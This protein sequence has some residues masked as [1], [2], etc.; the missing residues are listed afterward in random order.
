MGNP[1]HSFAWRTGLRAVIAVLCL[2]FPGVVMGQI[3][4]GNPI[5]PAPPP[6]PACPCAPESPGGPMTSA[7]GEAGAGCKVCSSS[8]A[9]AQSGVYFTSA[10]DLQLATAGPALVAGRVYNTSYVSSGLTGSGWTSN[11]AI[12]LTYSVYLY[13]APSTYQK[14]V[15]IRM[16]D[17]RLF[18]FMENADGVTYTPPLGRHDTLVKQPDGSWTLNVQNSRSAWQFNQDGSLVSITDDYGN[19]QTWSYDANGHLQRITDVGSGRYLDVYFGADGRLSSVQDSTGR[20]VQYTYN[21]NGSLAT[22]TDPLNHVTTY[23][24]GTGRFGPI[25]TQ[26]KDQWNRVVA[27][28]TYDSGDRVTSYNE[29][30]ETYTYDYSH[31]AQGYTVKKDSQNNQWTLAYPSVGYIT[32]VIAPGGAVKHTD[33]NADGSIQSVT[34]EVGIRTNYTY[35]SQGHV[36]TVARDVTHNGPRTDY[37]YDTNFP[38]KV[39]TVTVKNPSTNQ[40]DPNWQSWRYDYY[41][42]TDAAPGALHHVYRVEND[43]TT[44]DTV[45]TYTYDSHGRITQQI[46]ATGATTD[47]TYDTQGNLATVT[48]PANN[49]LGTRPATTYG[50]DAL[51]RVTSVTDPLGHETTATYDP[52]GRV[53]TVALPPPTQNSP[54]VF[55]TTYTYDNW[56]AASGLVFTTVTDP[57]GH[58]NRQGYDQLGRLVKSIDALGNSTT[59]VYTRDLLTSITDANNNVT[60]YAYDALKRLATTT[61]PDNASESYTYWNDGLLHTRTDRKGQTITYAYDAIKRLASKTYPGPS[62]ITYTY[63]GQRLTQVADTTV[64]PSETHTFG[65]DPSYRINAVTEGSR[66]TLG[67]TYASNDR[68]ATMSVQGGPTTTYAYY[69]DG[70]LDTI[71]WSPVTGQFKYAYMLNG[72]Y[73]AITFPNG[74]TRSYGYDDQGRLTALANVHPTAGTLASFAYGYDVDPQTQQATLLGQRTSLAMTIPSQSLTNATSTYR[75][76]ADY[77]LIQADYPTPAPYNGEVHGWTYDAIGNRLTNTV[78]GTPQ[79]YAYFKNGS[80]PL[81]GQRLSSDSDNAYTYDANGNNLTRNGTPGNFTFGWSADDRMASISGSATASYVYDYQGRRTSKTVSGTTRS[82]L[83][84]GSDLIRAT[85]PST[86]AEY[87]FGPDIDEPLATM[88]GGNVAYFSVDGLGSA[89]VVSDATGTVDNAYL[90]DAWG[91]VKNQSATLANDF[92]YTAREIGEANLWYYRA[93]FLQP[94]LGRFISEDPIGVLFGH[95]QL[96]PYV[97]NKPLAFRDAFGLQACPS[98]VPLPTPPDHQ[99]RTWGPLPCELQCEAV[100]FAAGGICLVVGGPEIDGPAALFHLGYEAAGHFICKA[101]CGEP[102]G[103]AVYPVTP[104][105]LPTPPGPPSP[106]PGCLQPPRCPAPEPKHAGPPVPSASTPYPRPGAPTPNLGSCSGS[107]SSA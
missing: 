38:D 6:Q 61:F 54:L 86:T 9:Y 4:C 39:A 91:A 48:G 14:E 40:V 106:G 50:Y 89:H 80:N 55:T 58:V 96:F 29:N 43:G 95:R 62:A 83:Y 67:Y 71:D 2:V 98:P 13:A 17:S 26:I 12:K 45:A 104:T 10:L 72:Q 7:L 33:F 8:P 94:G 53:L 81:N 105:P 46:T 27:T 57:N 37:T 66:G 36:L 41:Q 85:S 107:P 68:V 15:D 93:R 3:W 25:L 16:P 97:F 100:W 31:V 87:L 65:Y 34:D 103:G 64:S 84:N 63:Q 1:N 5:T 49:D 59:Y 21:T 90:Y 101:M 99:P 24:Y 19:A 30:G 35:D 42:T 92:G 51:G 60:S 52:L 22:V 56:D 78:N 75:Y 74:Q 88:Q 23:T 102:Q 44:L 76:D 28:M 18:T 47:Y 73:D 20:L 69:P 70:S 82:Y 79:N 77:Q 11:L 32:D